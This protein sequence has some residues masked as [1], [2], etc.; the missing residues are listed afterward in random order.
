MRF[1]ATPR[2]DRAELRL[3]RT[4]QKYFVLDRLFFARSLNMATSL[5]A[6][7]ANLGDPAAC[8]DRTCRRLSGHQQITLVARSRH[9]TTAPVGGPAG[10]PDFLNAALLI[11]TSLSPQELL[12]LLNQVELDLGR[13]RQA[14]WDQRVIDLDLLLYDTV[15]VNVD[16]L[17]IPHPRMAFRRFVLEPAVEIAPSLIHPQT[18]WSVQQLFDHLCSARNYIALVGPAGSGKTKLAIE[19]SEQ[20]HGHLL[21]SDNS[22]TEINSPRHGSQ[23]SWNNEW[24]CWPPSL[25]CSRNTL[26]MITGKDARVIL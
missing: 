19:V 13:Q 20:L 10:Q 21:L 8:F 11:E 17:M 26:K 6:F 5:I 7:G 14:R 24:T 4:R 22:L 3:G 12:L 18:G 16:N 15:T 9:Y 25:T 1:L 2:R 23:H